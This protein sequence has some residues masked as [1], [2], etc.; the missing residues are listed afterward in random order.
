MLLRYYLR[1]V[2]TV[3]IIVAS[4]IGPT[5]GLFERIPRG[6]FGPLGD[7]YAE[8]YWEREEPAIGSGPASVCLYSDPLGGLPLRECG[9]DKLSLIP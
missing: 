8:L 7:P 2:L 3:S 4:V 5:P 9:S 6:L 1:C